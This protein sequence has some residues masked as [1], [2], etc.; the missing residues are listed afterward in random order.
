M[1]LIEHADHSLLSARC[2]PENMINKPINGITDVQLAI[3]V[4]KNNRFRLKVMQKA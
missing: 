3:L 1:K 2:L 4:L